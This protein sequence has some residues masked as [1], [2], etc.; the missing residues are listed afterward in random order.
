[1]Y[2]SL[3][4]SL[5]VFFQV[6]VYVEDVNDNAPVFVLTPNEQETVQEN[7]PAGTVVAEFDAQDADQGL[8]AEVKCYIVVC[9][10]FS[11]ILIL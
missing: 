11:F 10:N 4:I 1:M 8:N 2:L 5:S 9:L 3:N 7:L 6:W